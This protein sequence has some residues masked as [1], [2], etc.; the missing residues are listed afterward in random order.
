[1]NGGT[2]TG[3]RVQSALKAEVRYAEFP[4]APYIEEEEEDDDEEEWLFV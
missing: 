3:V 4:P 2:K 1:V